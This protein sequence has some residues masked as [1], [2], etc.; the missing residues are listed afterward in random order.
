MSSPEGGKS[1][2]WLIQQ[3]NDITTDP[4]CFYLSLLPSSQIDVYSQACLLMVTTWLQKIQTSQYHITTSEDQK[5]AH[6][7][8]VLPF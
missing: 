3:F 6:P 5:E 2:G 7:F 4:D 1:Q 8:L